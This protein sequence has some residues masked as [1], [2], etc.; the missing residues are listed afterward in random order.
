MGV[1]T[2][3]VKA[4]LSLSSKVQRGRAGAPG[5]IEISTMWW[6]LASVLACADATAM[7]GEILSP[8]YP[9]AYPNEAEEVWDVQVP[10]G[11]G[12]HLYFTHL[13]IEPSQDCEYDSVK[14]LVNGLVEGVLCG[15]R[16]SQPPG[17]TVIEE[18]HVPYNHLRLAFQSDFSNEERFTGFAAYYVAEDVNECTDLAEAPCSH[19]C[20]NYIG[21][22]FCSCP[23]EY[24]LH[25]DMRN[26]GAN[27]SGDVFTALR[28]EI[29]S[30]NYPSPYPENSR[31]EYRVALEKGFQVVVT[32]KKDDFEVEPADSEGNC[33]DSLI[34]LTGNEQFGPFCGSGFPGPS[35]IETQSREL[36]I[37]FQ[38]DQT[39]QLKG[40]KIRY[41]GDPISCPKRFPT[42]S[43]Q[44]PLRNKYAFK[45]EVKVTC[46]EGFEVVKGK[47]SMT[48]FYASCQSNG[49]WSNSDLRCLPVDCGPPVAIPHGKSDH[50]RDTSFRAVT[51]YS[52]D[53]PSYYMKNEGKGAYRCAA[54]GSWV[55]DVLGVELPECAPVCGE[56]RVPIE[57]V[58]RVFGGTE[59]KIGNFPWQIFFQQPRAGGALVAE[60]WVLTAAHVV[61]D[62]A[63][64]TMYAG[65]ILVGHAG[66]QRAQ[67]LVADAVF[68]HPGW[69][70]VSD[71]TRRTDYDNDIALV[72]LKNPVEM[73]PNVAPVCL[74]GP[75]FHLSD[76]TLGYVS[77]W[78][79]KEDRDHVFKLRK[80][81]LPVVPMD[82]CRRVKSKKADTTAFR[83]TENMICAGERGADS[84]DGD[85]GGAFVVD[86]GEE[87]PKYFAAGLVSWGPECGTH[88]LYTRVA[89]Y[90]SWIEETMR[91]NDQ[92]P[93]ED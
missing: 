13:D 72:R 52:C 87:R 27:C 70:R 36:S 43:V 60:R 14:I 31:C 23:P 19:F 74:P 44:E 47:T 63:S 85:S 73:G 6:F 10:E 5:S 71:P 75:D 16:G 45:D 91:E 3:A 37:I 9:Q 69:K 4:I 7:Y 48:S 39:T 59:A 35:K 81:K 76:G 66:L 65:A 38:T 49:Q 42:N 29:S 64:P 54:N 84:C 8:S 86:L 93:S 80:A 67:A 2:V 1:R 61:E 20:N 89:N 21:G 18:F 88:G 50:P 33:P 34:F 57:D 25:S 90:L 83:F 68:V 28:G 79:K 40:W 17:S 51:H 56:P 78:G 58:E 26:C 92:P 46:T 77:G 24:F 15:R 55:N 11:Y 53:E 82:R 30:P 32:V 62:T 12:I 41:Y 22:F